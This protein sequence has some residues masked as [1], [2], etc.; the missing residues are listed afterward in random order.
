MEQLIWVVHKKDMKQFAV[1][2]KPVLGKPYNVT[3]H[4]RPQ[5]HLVM[6]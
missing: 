2:L 6:P 5:L 4:M 3:K 1:T